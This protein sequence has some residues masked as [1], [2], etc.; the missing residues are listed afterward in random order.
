MPAPFRKSPAKIQ[1][2]IELHEQGASAREIAED[3]GLGSHMT[4][5]AWL[6]DSGLEPNGGHGSRKARH[7]VPPSGAQAKLATAQKEL[8]ALS[9][10]PPP[11]DFGDV[12][13]RMLQQ[14]HQIEALVQY[15]LIHAGQG[16]STMA[17]LQ[18][19]AQV[20]E[21][22]AIKIRELSPKEAPDPDRDP[23]N[24]E[25]AAEARR[26]FQSMVETAERAV[27]CRHCGANPFV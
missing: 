14:Y 20:Q 7:R 6:R 15:H 23:A 21:Q 5:L 12:L 3:L 1:R 22:W 13:Q 18:K 19:A 8:A 17:E 10:G 26:R 11:R 2:L 24:V 16:E 9:Q 4:A 27:R 25:A